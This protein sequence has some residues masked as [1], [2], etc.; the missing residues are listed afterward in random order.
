MSS[1]DQTSGASL[2]IRAL[3]CNAAAG[4]SAGN[5]PFF[6]FFC[7]E[8]FPILGSVLMGISQFRNF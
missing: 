2:Y 4:A 8:L 6:F 5:L 3:I 7:F 1:N